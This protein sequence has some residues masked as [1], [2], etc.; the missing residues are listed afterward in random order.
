MRRHP[1]IRALRV[2]KMTLAGLEGT[3]RL[4][5]DEEALQKIPTLAALAQSSDLCHKR[6]AALAAALAAAGLP[7]DIALIEVDDSVGGGAARASSCPVG[8]SRSGP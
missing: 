1:L 6:G 3:L 5:R 2:D 4:Y 7:A 8:A